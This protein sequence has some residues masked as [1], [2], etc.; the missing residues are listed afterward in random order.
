M[1][2]FINLPINKKLQSIWLQE[3]YSH[4]LPLSRSSENINS[5]SENN[6]ISIRPYSPFP[7]FFPVLPKNS[8]EKM[9]ILLRFNKIIRAEI[10]TQ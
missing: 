5:A 6:I 10:I 1:S 7:V 8:L 3:P 9:T 4:F 2:E